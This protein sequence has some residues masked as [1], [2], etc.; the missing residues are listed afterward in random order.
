VSS[1]VKAA[2]DNI[3]NEIQTIQQLAD[4]ASKH[5]YYKFNY[6]WT[7][8]VQDA[9]SGQPPSRIT[10]HA[11]YLPFGSATRLCFARG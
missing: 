5:P 6:A 10:S 4:V 11:G 1:V 3:N 9:V 7:R 2:Q 8:Q